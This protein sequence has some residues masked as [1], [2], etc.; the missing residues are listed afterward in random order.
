MVLA[1]AWVLVILRSAVYLAYEH[2]T[3]DSDQAI[4]GLMAKHLL[5]GR[6]FPLFMYGQPYMLAVDSWVATPFVFVLGPTVFALHLSLVFSNLV[7]TTLLIAGLQ[8]WSGMPPRHALVAVA[9]FVCAPPVT[10][11]SLLEAAGN[12]GPLV[13]VPIIWSLRDRPLWFGFVFAFGCLHR[14][15]TVYT[16]PVILALQAWDRTLWTEDRLRKWLVAA[17]VSAATW[18]GVQALRPFADSMGPGTHGSRTGDTSLG[19]VGARVE[20]V[21][22]ELGGRIWTMA[23]EH[24]PGMFGARLLVT[25]TATQGRDWLFWPFMSGLI[26][27]GSGSVIALARRR[28]VSPRDHRVMP[29]APATHF[30]LFL[31]GVGL[32]AVAGYV[33]TRPADFF[34]DRYML[35]SLYLPVGLLAFMFA[36][37]TSRWLRVGVTAV[38]VVVALSSAVDHVRLAQR[39][40]GNREP[41]DLRVLVDGLVSRG[42]RVA[43]ASYWRAYKI[44]Y[45]SG[46][47]IKVA[48]SDVVRITEYQRLADAEGD[49]VVVIGDTPCAGGTPIGVWQICRRDGQPIAAGP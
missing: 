48:S 39:Y 31:A 47:R 23:T 5:E 12:I 46:E 1:V 32:L 11:A 22:A 7:A 49:R 18:Q 3:F 17:A 24:F 42:V 35:L 26:A 10:A 45:M 6:A 30:P 15:F 4:Y 16:A 14:E 20:F 21:P 19:S 13:Y 33:V 41:N 27:A 2:S 34:L 28:R 25:P 40:W 8:R 29:H 36:T 43:V 37:V 44:T 38:V 9:A